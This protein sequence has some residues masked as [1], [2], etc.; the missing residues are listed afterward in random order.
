LHL[1][2]QHSPSAETIQGAFFLFSLV[3]G[4]IFRLKASFN[5]YVDRELPNIR[6]EV[7]GPSPLSAGSALTVVIS[8]AT[9]ATLAAVQGAAHHFTRFAITGADCRLSIG[10]AL[11]AIPKVV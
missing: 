8:T 9:G 10:F 7:R 4:L 1:T 6:A 2:L 5:A 3:L 11:Q